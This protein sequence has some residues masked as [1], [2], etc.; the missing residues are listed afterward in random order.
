MLVAS[1]LLKIEIDDD[2]VGQRWPCDVLGA[3]LIFRADGEGVEE[4]LRQVARHRVEAEAVGV[5]QHITACIADDC[6]A[7]APGLTV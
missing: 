1:L 3:K 7:Q 2:R 6:S 4:Y 5:E